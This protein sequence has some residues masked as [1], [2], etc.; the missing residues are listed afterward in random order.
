[1]DT[2]DARSE[3][4]PGPW[5]FWLNALRGRN[6]GPLLLAFVSGGIFLPFLTPTLSHFG[7]KLE[8][9]IF[10]NKNIVAIAVCAPL[11]NA[12]LIL[13]AR[14]SSGTKL[15]FDAPLSVMNDTRIIVTNTSGAA[16]KKMTITALPIPGGD[17]KATPLYSFVYTSSIR[18][19]KE[20]EPT[21]DR[22][23]GLIELDIPALNPDE[24]VVINTGF[25]V[26]VGFLVEVF[27]EGVAKQSY[28]EAGCPRSFRMPNRLFAGASAQYASDQCSIDK[29]TQQLSCKLRYEFPFQIPNG[30]KV[31][32]LQEERHIVMDP[33]TGENYPPR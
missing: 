26:P 9:I 24:I 21:L 14:S 5:G 22:E 10:G 27:G 17:S 29:D 25:S 8:R 19:S 3:K 31:E 2:N 6:Y 11:K 16:I 28:F 23:N 4:S 12:R 30:M 32:S 33:D 20:Y 15:L 7:N 18:G 1:M 13:R